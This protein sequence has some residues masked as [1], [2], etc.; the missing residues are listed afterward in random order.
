[1]KLVEF[2]L[3]RLVGPTHHFGGLGVGN[4]A[5]QRSAGMTSNPAAAAIQGLDKMRLIARWTN[6][7]LIV[8][9]QPRPDFSMLRMLGW[10]GPD[11][12]VLKR[13]RDEAPILLSA[14]TSC[15]AMWTANAATASPAVDSIP[16]ANHP[17]RLTV[18]NLNSSI[19]RAM[20][21]VQT[22][23]DLDSAL[24]SCGRVTSPLPGGTAMR[25]EGAAN[26]MRLGSSAWEPGIHLFVYG[27]G[28]PRPRINFPRQSLHA[29]EAIARRHRLIPENVFFLKQHPDAIDAGAFHNDVVAMSHLDRLIYHASAFYA[30]EETLHQIDQRYQQLHGRDLM[31]ME[32]TDAMLPLSEAVS[33]YLFNSQIVSVDGDAAPRIVCT[34]QV[35][36]SEKARA[37]VEQWCNEGIFRSVQYVDLDQS[38]SGGGGPACLRLRIPVVSDDVDDVAPS[39][40]FS[41][42][43]D[44][45]LREEIQSRYPTKVTIDDLASLEFHRHA[46]ETQRSPPISTRSPSTSAS[47]SALA[48]ALAR[49]HA[50]GSRAHTRRGRRRARARPQSTRTATWCRAR[51][52]RRGSGRS[53]TRAISPSSPAPSCP[54]YP[55][56]SWT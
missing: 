9:P 3:D 55:R 52:L 11:E 40:R 22:Q 16:S 28:E 18:A 51:S 7:Q 34:R 15:S 37:L 47:A 31:R 21:P 50:R 13:A 4:L 29:C 27:D 43:L 26:H 35:E 53:W 8:P 38:M 48:P 20:E 30:G 39:A 46:A 54:R 12:E 44:Q 32:V 24:A 17:T 41:D 1:M 45:Q 5:S 10:D 42:E 2:Q 25:D 14:A 23:L 6:L 19:H 36:K 49:S 56:R 33:T